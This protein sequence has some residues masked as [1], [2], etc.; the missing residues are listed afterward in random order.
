MDLSTKTITSNSVGRIMPPIETKVSRSSSSV[1][2]STLS[3]LA[4]AALRSRGYPYCSPAYDPL[5][6]YGR[7]VELFLQKELI[8]EDPHE[9]HDYVY[10]F[11]VRNGKGCTTIQASV[12]ACVSMQS[13]NDF[14]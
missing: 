12:L 11:E 4:V 8:Y 13:P 14:C 3:A 2:A 1:S 6:A 5:A 9:S 7:G 10:C